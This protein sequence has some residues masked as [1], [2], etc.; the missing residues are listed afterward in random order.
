MRTLDEHGIVHHD[1]KPA[2]ILLG[3]DGTPMLLDFNAAEDTKRQGGSLLA[4]VAG[5]LP[6]LAPE[7]LAAFQD[8]SVAVD[9]R[10]DLY[11]FGVILFELLTGQ[12]PFRDRHPVLALH[13]DR[14]LEERR[15]PPPSLRT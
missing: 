13:L 6:Y 11:A 12:Y 4:W 10:S 3:D 15:S 1:L 14:V 9:A 8:P 5:T 7:R 2:N